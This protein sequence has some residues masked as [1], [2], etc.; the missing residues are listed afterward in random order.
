MTEWIIIA[1]EAVDSYQ[2]IRRSGRID[3]YQSRPLKKAQAGDAAYVYETKV[4]AIRWKCAVTEV[5]RDGGP[6]LALKTLREY[7]LW[8]LLSLDRLRDNGYR[9]NMQGPCRVRPEL[10]AYL[11]R[12]DQM[13]ASEAGLLALSGELSTQDLREAA[14]AHGRRR[15]SAELSPV[16]RYGRSALVAAYARR[17]AEG[18]CE[19][20]GE[21]APFLDREGNPFL[22]VHHVRWLS[23][24]GADSIDNTAALCPNCHRRMHIV[25]DPQDI[26]RLKSV[27]EEEASHV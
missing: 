12:M 26:A 25:Q 8:R 5:R 9:G 13:Q 4:H 15:P 16:K 10:G 27:L 3:W 2:E 17:R 19:L 18:R 24:G 20:C 1:N 6:Y 22:E 23:Q 14:I 21:K 7:P 11:H